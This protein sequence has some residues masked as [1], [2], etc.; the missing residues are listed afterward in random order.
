MKNYLTTLLVLFISI[1]LH[2]AFALD[3]NIENIIVS[4]TRSDAY[5]G[6]LPGNVTVITAEDIEISGATHLVDVL[7]G[8]GGMQISD[9]YGDGTD[10]SVGL[11]GFS[12][13][14]QQNTLIMIDGRRLNNADNGLPNLNTV[15]LK[16]VKQIEIIKSS[17]GALYGDKAVGGVIN[18]ITREP[19]SFSAEI[20]TEFGSYSN[21]SG[22]ASIENRHGNGVIY[23]VGGLR[24]LNDNYRDNNNLQLT[25]LTT[26]VGVEHK[27]GKLFFEFQDLNEDILIPGPL[28]DD[29]RRSNRKQALNA[30]DFVDTDTRLYRVGI[31]HA[32]GR[33][34]TMFGEYTHRH[35]DIQ[36]QLSSGGV[37]SNFLSER[38]HIEFTPRVIGRFETLVGQMLVTVG[39]DLFKTDYLIS[40]DFGITDDT[41]SQISIYTQAIVPITERFNITA[42][43]RH[44]K[45]KN[46]IFVDTVAFGRSL[47]EGT[48]IDDS[49]NAWEMGISYEINPDW[50]LFAKLDRNFR[51]VT[52]DE[53]SAVADGNF[54]STLFSFGS[55]IPLPQTQIGLSYEAGG[56]W[57]GGNNRI[58]IQGFQMDMDNEIVFDP[59]LFLNTN[60]GDTRRRGFIFEG[61][62][63]LSD[64]LNFSVQYSYLDSSITSGVFKGSDL[65]FISK[66]TASF[67]AQYRHDDHFSGYLELHGVSERI[68][69]G[70]FAN[71]FSSLPG[72]VVGNMNLS[73]RFNNI[74]LS[75]RI[76]N[77]L[78]KT[79]SDSGSLGND[80]RVPFPSPQVETFFPAPKRNFLL[81]LAYHYQ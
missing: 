7:R 13:S 31:K 71:T 77:L 39:I 36:G 40:S 9:L 20:N 11:R 47:P 43:I 68:L 48:E 25:N 12:S 65:T 54:F 27:S 57:T 15:A 61:E 1:S 72:Y 26:M 74:S 41:Q 10:A 79:Y 32:L 49:A 62:Y 18:I 24:Q 44:S 46:N 45:V 5:T 60:I 80:F 75:L 37:P 6:T 19:E 55:V 70:N 3:G 78:D 69:G 38:R 42:G 53:Y 63:V 30:G 73:Y 67:R 33:N 17:M 52:A 58:N 59:V 8:Y 56:E 81:S 23:R 64:K 21:R 14:A 4:A 51:F 66:N 2:P 76:N 29:L 28:F 16:N 34:F 22:F 50:R 35:N